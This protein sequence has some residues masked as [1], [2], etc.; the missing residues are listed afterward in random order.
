MVERGV[1]FGA[2]FLAGPSPTAVLSP[3]LVFLAVNDAYLEVSGRGREELVGQDVFTAFPDNPDDPRGARTLRGSLERVLATGQRHVMPLQRY[4]VA[5]AGQPGVVE[6]RFWSTVNAPVPDEDGSVRWIL[7]RVEEVTRFLGQ[8]PPDDAGVGERQAM[9]AEVFARSQEL[10][11]A[12]EQLAAAA[13]ITAAVLADAP[14]AE[15]LE[16]IATRARGIAGVDQTLVLVP[17][18]SREHLVVAASAGPQADAYRSLR[19]PL[20]GAAGPGPAPVSV[21]V[22]RTGRSVI[23]EDAA[24]A[25]RTAGLG[26]EVAVGA[27]LA[28]PLGP[29]D[30]VRGVLA[31]VNT[32]GHSITPTG[33]VRS[34]ELF[35]AQAAIVLE[36]AERRRD[37][38]LVSVLDD[39]E[40]IARE[41]N[42]AVAGRLSTIATG[43]TATLKIIPREDAVRRVRDAARAV[44]QVIQQLNSAVFAIDADPPRERAL[45]R[46]IQ[47]LVDAAAE[48]LD[49]AMTSRLDS[50]LD[51]ALRGPVRDRLMAVLDAALSGV[52]RRSGA[53]HVTVTVELRP[54]P[55]PGCLFV[56]VEDDGVPAPPES[57]GEPAGL[58]LAARPDGGTAATWQV[59]LADDVAVRS[60]R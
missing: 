1:D 39:R 58:T 19:L 54:E 8:L 45:H 17:D 41:L 12:N 50:R 24:P 36:L 23:S 27:A 57:G 7:H 30:A 21:R 55:G 10:H 43:L 56:Q 32:P 22:F 29:P 60:A 44:D 31:V 3:S 53:R 6:Q 38:V 40:R 16:L 46:R 14:A 2:V 59:P 26:P 49:V 42:T 47:D 48:T 28:V 11:Q 51:T 20:A 4:D 9:Q 18:D 13:D 33:V 34:L 5:V 35:A 25:A 52:A 37:A 15:V